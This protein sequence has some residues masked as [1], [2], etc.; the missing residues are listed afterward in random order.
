MRRVVRSNWMKPAFALG[1]SI[2]LLPF[3]GCGGGMQDSL[4]KPKP[5]YGS[6]TVGVIFP[7]DIAREIPGFTTQIDIAVS[8]LG[9]PEALSATATPASPTASF[10]NVP[11]G[12][13]FVLAW[14]N[15]DPDGI[16]PVYAAIAG[17]SVASGQTTNVE[18]E[19][20]PFGKKLRWGMVDVTY[21]ALTA[22]MLDENGNGEIGR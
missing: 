9:L 4:T 12:E 17:V 6:I 5:G 16:Y 20:Q 10:T 2:T 15:E 21:D 3:L 18:L 13:Y 8:G 7:E 1:L 19:L 22:T 11:E 14:T